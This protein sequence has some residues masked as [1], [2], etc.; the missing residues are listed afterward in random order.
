MNDQNIYDDNDFFEGYKKLRE[1]HFAANDIV[2]NRH[3]SHCAL[4]L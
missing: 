3:C 2:E 4:I 1:N